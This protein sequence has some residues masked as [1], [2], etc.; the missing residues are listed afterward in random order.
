MRPYL[1]VSLSILFVLLTVSIISLSPSASAD[2]PE[3]FEEGYFKYSIQ[4]DYAVI[5]EYIGEEIEVVDVPDTVTYNGED[6]EVKKILCTF[7][8]DYIEV[9]NIGRNIVSIIDSCFQAPNLEEINVAEDNGT[10]SSFD[11]VL[12]NKGMNTLIKYPEGRIDE[13]YEVPDA[14]SYIGPFS[15]EYSD[16]LTEVILNDGLVKIGRYAFSDCTALEHISSSDGADTF[17]STLSMIGEFAFYRCGNLKS[18]ALPDE[19]EVI[20]Q[21]AFEY[22]GMEIVELPYMLW[23]IGDRA[24]SNCTNLTKFDFT[25]GYSMH[26]EIHDGVLYSMTDPITLKSYPAGKDTEVFTVYDNTGNIDHSAFSGCKYLKE[27]ILNDNIVIIDSG[28]F[29]GCHSLEKIDLTNVLSIGSCAFFECKNLTDVTFGEYLYYIDSDAFNGTGIRSVTFGDNLKEIGVNVFSQCR[30][31]TEVVISENCKMTLENYTF[32]GCLNM[33]KITVK[34]YDAVF[35]AGSLDIGYS[36]ESLTTVDVYVRSGYSI[37]DD[38]V[39]EFTVLNV[40]EEGKKPY[41]YENLIV[42]F[43]CVLLIIGILLFVREV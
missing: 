35:D 26:F 33:E 4:T 24:F 1:P 34:G 6:Y 3:P 28:A 2:D 39:G 7:F 16:Y 43:F 8:D 10:F 22:C 12:F 5:F 23:S 9:V 11:G 18:F 27:V 42:V 19:L 25:R 37:P 29:E 30:N 38:A 17:P 40:I 13:I 15:F 41:P 20:G 31:L 32:Y 36:E 14:V 21:S